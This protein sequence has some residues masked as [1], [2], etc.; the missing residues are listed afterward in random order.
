MVPSKVPPRAAAPRGM[1]NGNPAAP[2]PGIGL[3]DVGARN[4]VIKTAMLRKVLL[5]VILRKVPLC[6][7]FVIHGLVLTRSSFF[8]ILIFGKIGDHAVS[9]VDF[10]AAP[11][12]CSFFYSPLRQTFLEGS[13]PKR[14]N[15]KFLIKEVA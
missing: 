2:A 5:G 7:F 15:Q 6:A 12:R 4:L 3:P 13:P 9:P 8:G 10:G 11:L 14:G 1:E